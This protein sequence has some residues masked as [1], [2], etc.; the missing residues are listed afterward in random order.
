MDLTDAIITPIKTLCCFETQKGD[1]D[2]VKMGQCSITPSHHILMEEGWM[3]AR[4]A[5]ARGQGEVFRS[6]AE[7]VYNIYLEGGGNIIINASRQLGSVTLTTAAT[8]GYL[9]TPTPDSQQIGSVIYPE[10]I[11]TQLGSRQDLSKGNARFWPGDVK[12]LPNGKLIFKNISGDIPPKN[13]SGKGP[14]L[15]Q[16][17]P[18]PGSLAA[19]R[20]MSS[21]SQRAITLA[22]A[23]LQLGRPSFGPGEIQILPKE[24]L[25]LTDT[26]GDIPPLTKLSTDPLLPRIPATLGAGLNEA[27]TKQWLIKRIMQDKGLL[28][29][30][31]S[32]RVQ[33]IWAGSGDGV[34]MPASFTNHRVT[35]ESPA[36]LEPSKATSRH[37]PEP[38]S[39]PHRDPQ[40][41]LAVTDATVKQDP[42]LSQ[43]MTQA[44]WYKPSYAPDTLLLILNSGQAT[45]TPIGEVQVGATAIQS[46]PSGTTR[47]VSGAKLT[48]IE[49]KLTFRQAGGVIDMVKLGM[50]HFTMHHPILTVEGWMTADKDLGRSFP[51][52]YTR[53]CT[54]SS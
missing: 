23:H 42:H 54:A 44:T 3:T 36:L 19:K 39:E 13:P 51:T 20:L 30:D 15:S 38:E 21:D 22:T 1:N 33:A 9:F 40:P 50:A 2:M 14:K 24:E 16:T 7:R 45:W 31:K 17:T 43:T 6:R 53:T 47:N 29:Q 11:R 10:D 32:R 18:L 5:A 26:K 41:K 52:G 12:T 4:Q 35:V 49:R 27:L 37:T 28:H 25:P 34:N 8:M 46:L 48:T